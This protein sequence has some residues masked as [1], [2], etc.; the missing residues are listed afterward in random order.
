MEEDVL[1][2]EDAAILLSLFL[3]QFIAMFALNREKVR[4]QE[5]TIRQQQAHL[6]L[7][8]ELQIELRSFR[9][10]FQN[11][12]SGV[13]LQ[14][15]EGDLEGIGQGRHGRQGSG[16][17]LLVAA[18]AHQCQGQDQLRAATEDTAVELPSME[19]PV[20]MN[21]RDGCA[22]QDDHPTEINPR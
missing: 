13:A 22:P 20:L 1:H 6:R 16:V 3:L 17:M 10:D 8:E 2:A 15:R 11:L 14:A 21:K 4:T 12:L 5:E 9:H 19:K 7:L 18:L